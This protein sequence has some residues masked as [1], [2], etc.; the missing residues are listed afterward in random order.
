MAN[1]FARRPTSCQ[2]V[3]SR[4]VHVHI[5]LALTVPHLRLEFGSSGARQA[6][7]THAR[8]PNTVCTLGVRWAPQRRYFVGVRPTKGL[9]T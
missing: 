4:K 6:P 3:S 8:F 1:Y 7:Q 2:A 9:I 5:S